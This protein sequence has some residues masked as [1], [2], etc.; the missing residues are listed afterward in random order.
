MF[1]NGEHIGT[2]MYGEGIVARSFRGA[3]GTVEHVLSVRPPEDL[4]FEG[5][6]KALQ[7][8][9]HQ[10]QKFLDLTPSTAVFRR[11]F[12]SDILNQAEAVKQSDLV[13]A[14]TATSIIG[15]PPLPQGRIELIAY[16]VTGG[17]PAVKERLSPNHLLIKRGRQRHLW[18]T[19]LCARGGEHAVSAAEQTREVFGDLIAALKSQD[20]RLSDH[21][22]RTWIYVKD[23][24]IFYSAMVKSRSAVFEVEG[25]TRSTHYIA[26]TGIEGRCAHRD[27]LV[28]M[29][30]YSNLDLKPGQMTYLNDFDRLC[31]T[32]DYNVTFERAT[33]VAY[34][35]RAHCFISGTASIDKEGQILHV[36][37]VARQLDRALE[38]VS[39]L[40]KAGAATFD[41]MMYLIVYLRDPADFEAVEEILVERFPELPTVI[42]QGPVCRPAWLVEVEGVAVTRNHAPELPAF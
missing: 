1:K 27:D 30:A 2:S 15:Q 4:P 42:V 10:A 28:A 41:D 37:D 35:D 16:H 12:L 29:D 25:L 21:C 6:L 11:V 23:I 39:A 19:R 3:G 7:E 17:E 32:K 24:D 8:R 13:D 22:V 20:A 31:P 26:S 9:Y 36:G 18:T 33:R 38:N 34:A 14:G 5:Q 40:L